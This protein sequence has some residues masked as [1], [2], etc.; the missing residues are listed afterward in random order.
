MEVA[1]SKELELQR[2]A[3]ELFHERT[4]RETFD[5]LE[6][7]DVR[8]RFLENS[9]PVARAWLQVYMVNAPKDTH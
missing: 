6:S 3:T 1:R 7:D 4:W 8:L 2:R 5:E 9:T